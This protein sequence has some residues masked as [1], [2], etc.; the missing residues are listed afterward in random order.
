[1]KRV[2]ILSLL[3]LQ[4]AMITAQELKFSK[5][6]ELKIVQFTDTHIKLGNDFLRKGSDECIELMCELLDSE[7]PDV[8]IFT[9][10]NVTCTPAKPGW[11]L[12]LKPIADRN[13][14]FG[15]VLGN[16]DREHDM[17]WAE[18]SEYVTSY[19]NCIN[20]LNGDLLA[21]F[22]VEVAA[23]KGDKTAAL[24]YLLDS[25]EYPTI[26]GVGGSGYFTFEQ[27]DS[28]RKMSAERKENNGG[29]VIP[30][31]AFFHIPLCEYDLASGDKDNKRIGI[32]G[33]GGG[34]KTLNTG[35]YSAFLESGDIFATFAGHNHNNDY[36]VGY[37]GIALVY[38]RATLSKTSYSDLRRGSR[39]IVLK[40]GCR[41]FESWI[42][43][44]G[45]DLTYPMSFEKGE[46]IKLKK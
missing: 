33:E 38:G 39:V 24:L 4:V 6:G 32:A 11:D 43:E 1:M 5:D 35:M 18:I 13:I 44:P 20:E 19:P 12:L 29:V 7:R 31:L 34:S 23:S 41:E 3:L 21:D 42:Y 26:D 36:A 8:V 30:A 15:V 14:P 2:I 9:G 16:H 22:A 45:G 40:E 37:N 27:V 17:T 10:D 46:V 25:N 28:F